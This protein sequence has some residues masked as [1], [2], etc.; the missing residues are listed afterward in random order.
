MLGL[1]CRYR[2]LRNQ[3]AG[4]SAAIVE[5]SLGKA[6]KA[7]AALFAIVDGW[8]PIKLWYGFR[9]ALNPGNDDQRYDKLV[10][11]AYQSRGLWL[12]AGCRCYS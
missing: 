11:H 10:R 1:T 6:D 5:A 4:I 9:S 12:Q 7:H 2:T 8:R 3:E